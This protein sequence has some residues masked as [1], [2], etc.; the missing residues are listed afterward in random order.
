MSHK[1]KSV[2]QAKLTKLAIQIGYAGEI[3]C[4]SSYAASVVN[5]PVTHFYICTNDCKLHCVSKNVTLLTFP[6]TSSDVG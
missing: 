2:L 4:S 6:I 3:H 5:N 1:E